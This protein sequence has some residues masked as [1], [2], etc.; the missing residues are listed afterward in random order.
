M[1]IVAIL[2]IAIAPMIAIRYDPV[3]SIMA[4]ALIGPIKAPNPAEVN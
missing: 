3:E 2:E 1:A 4:P